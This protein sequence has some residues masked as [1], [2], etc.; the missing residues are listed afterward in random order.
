MA[1][2]G[3]QGGLAVEV[4][5]VRR[6]QDERPR[7]AGA[8]RH[9]EGPREVEVAQVGL[10]AGGLLPVAEAQPPGPVGRDLRVQGE[11]P[12]RGPVVGEAH[13]EAALDPVDRGAG[14]ARV[15]PCS[16][17]SVVSGETASSSGRDP[18]ASR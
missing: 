9:V 14:P 12:E 2:R 16:S 10:A 15:A 1:V 5:I 3:V 13:A 17:R 4:G 6:R 7:P 8:E 18:R 11:D